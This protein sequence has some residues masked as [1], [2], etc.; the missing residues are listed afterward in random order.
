MRRTANAYSTTASYSATRLLDPDNHR[1]LEVRR[2]AEGE[3]LSSALGL[4]AIGMDE[5]PYYRYFECNDYIR[6]SPGL[7]VQPP[8][9]VIQ[10][11]QEEHARQLT[12]YTK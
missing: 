12:I 4:D 7:S 9:E 2:E 6:N 11:G 5:K 8:P 3:T 1:P 10:M